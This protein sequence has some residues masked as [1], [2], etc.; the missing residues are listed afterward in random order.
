MREAG[1]GQLVYRLPPEER[2]ESVW[3]QATDGFHQIGGARMALSRETGV[4]DNNC[5]VFDLPNVYIAS[6][7]IFPSSSQANP[8]FMGV[9]LALRLADHLALTRSADKGFA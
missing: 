1:V 4:V 5:R 2:K 6:S 8:T 9:A 7:C 3:D